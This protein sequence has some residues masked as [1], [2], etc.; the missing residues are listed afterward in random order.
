MALRLMSLL[1]SVSFLAAGCSTMSDAI[2]SINPFASRGPK[3]AKLEPVN[4]TIGVRDQWSASVG[5]AG[6][7]IFSPA[8]VGNA[9]FVAARNGE[10]SKLVDGRKEWSI[11]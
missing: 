3:M 9:V 5:K 1:A 8:V 11:N 6:D 10:I 2:D 7:Y 4:P